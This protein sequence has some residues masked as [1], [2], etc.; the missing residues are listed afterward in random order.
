VRQ[1]SCCQ[2][3][4]RCCQPSWLYD[5]VLAPSQNTAAAAWHLR[6]APGCT[7]A[8]RN[9]CY[10][11]QPSSRELPRRRPCCCCPQQSPEVP[12]SILLSPSPARQAT[13]QAEL[14]PPALLLPVL[15]L[16]PLLLSSAGAASLKL[17]S[18]SSSPVFFRKR[19][20]RPSSVTL[21]PTRLRV[22][23]HREKCR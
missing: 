14:S 21:M 13:A 6:C 15:S 7:F 16:L 2:H 3:N 10:I 17:R 23:K 1:S 9:R 12:P 8:T 11:L 4:R 5:R 19:T 18:G 22:C 20:L